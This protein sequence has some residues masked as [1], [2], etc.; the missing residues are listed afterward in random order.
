[1]TKYAADFLSLN[2]RGYHA[3]I[4]LSCLLYLCAFLS[5]A[6]QRYLRWRWPI[7]L[8]R[9][10]VAVALRPTFIPV[11][12]AHSKMVFGCIGNWQDSNAKH[13]FFDVMCHEPV[14]KVYTAIS[15]IC[16]V[17]FAFASIH[18]AMCWVELNPN[19]RVDLGDRISAFA[20]ANGR[21]LALN[22][23]FRV[24]CICFFVTFVQF[25]Y[26][27]WPLALLLL[28]AGAVNLYYQLRHLPH[29]FRSVQVATVWSNAVI[30]WTA[31]CIIINS[32]QFSDHYGSLLTLYSMWPVLLLI[33]ILAVQARVNQVIS[34]S[35]LMLTY[36]SLVS[37]KAR[38]TL[39]EGLHTLG[40]DKPWVV[41]TPEQQNLREKLYRDVEAI[42]Q[43]GTRRFPTDPWL[44][45]HLALFYSCY[46]N[47]KP[48]FYRE[49]FAAGE[50]ASAPDV[51][52]FLFLMRARSDVESALLRS[53]D[54]QVKSYTEFKERTVAAAAAA[55]NAARAMLEFWSDLVRATPNT[56]RLIRLAALARVSTM[57]ALTNYQRLL[58]INPA[59]VSTLR[60]FGGF[61]LDFNGDVSMSSQLLHRADELEEARSDV[62]AG[63]SCE[64]RL[65]ALQ[66]TNLDIYDERNAVLS[67]S[68][69]RE[70]FASIVS[71]NAA[72]RRITGY[73][74]PNELLNRNVSIIIPEPISSVH[75]QILT[76]FLRRNT[77]EILNTTRVAL[78]V[79]KRGYLVTA[80]INMRWVDATMSRV[81]GVIKPLIT[82]DEQLIFD[83]ESDHVTYCT[84]NLY[85]MLGFS[86]ELIVGKEV[87]ISGIFPHLSIHRATTGK[88]R[89]RRDFFL[90]C[91]NQPQG[92]I[93]PARNF[94]DGRLSL[95]RIWMYTMQV[96]DV[97]ISI[98]RISRKI[99]REHLLS[100]ANVIGFTEF[101]RNGQG[102]LLQDVDTVFET[103]T[104][105]RWRRPEDNV[106]LKLT[107]NGWVI[108]R[109]LAEDGKEVDP[110][111]F[112]ATEGSTV[113][114]RFVEDY[115]N[116]SQP[117]TATHF[118]VIPPP[119]ST[120]HPDEPIAD[121]EDHSFIMSPSNN[122]QSRFIAIHK[123]KTSQSSRKILGPLGST[124]SVRSVPAPGRTISAAGT[125]TFT[126][127]THSKP[128]NLDTVA[129]EGAYSSD[130]ETDLGQDPSLNGVARALGSPATT[131]ALTTNIHMSKAQQRIAASALSLLDA[132]AM[133]QPGKKTNSTDRA[134]QRSEM[135]N[136]ESHLLLSS[137]SD[138]DNQS[139]KTKSDSLLSGSSG[140][141]S[142]ITDA[143]TKMLGNR[144][145]LHFI[146]E[147]NKHNKTI[148]GRMHGLVMIGVTS[149]LAVIIAMFVLTMNSIHDNE[150][151]TE[152]LV[153]ACHRR[154]LSMPILTFTNALE[155][156]RLEFYDADYQIDV[157]TTMR[158]AIVQ[159]RELDAS[160]YD[161]R[162]A[163]QEG[164]EFFLKPSI[165]FHVLTNGQPDTRLYNLKEYSQAYINAAAAMLTLPI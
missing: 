135:T 93:L 102:I 35:T 118:K 5:V 119:P 124:I 77:S 147:Q 127:P 86:R 112:N 50:N 52:F 153:S 82:E 104:S 138:P 146:R 15:V 143:D 161:E 79:H 60:S 133:L 137:R 8:Y 44:H 11:L 64:L 142:S 144:H 160:L 91:A 84:Q 128:K 101:E 132:K 131:S 113:S 148:V 111:D 59:S 105:W 16:G 145:I 14:T 55:R 13:A 41:V 9:F 130:E 115:S 88:M 116:Q 89:R 149:I 29:Y 114:A 7:S 12:L 23:F 123:D 78:A 106:S 73:T 92:L 26:A 45:I 109:T 21:G 3:A 2:I 121:E 154:L 51:A 30:V 96:Q 136:P 58:E 24:L 141:S 40:L 6:A 70:N 81:V 152:Y 94:G 99:E 74:L 47:N 56:D 134:D 76:T 108:L 83:K 156:V 165:V 25:N 43:L 162:L 61:V 4:S 100:N 68:L 163:T 151:V 71:T 87:H 75:D 38:L 139:V 66:R 31:L 20:G 36:P 80:D 39:Y 72:F 125:P 95:V 22:L 107:T 19:Q 97:Y 157:I 65:F 34:Y 69:E 129:S 155:L 126:Q 120:T 150:T 140:G 53:M 27:R 33:S 46:I 103:T 67:I 62:T 164:R 17:T 158:N 90:E 1:M 10:L 117:P 37:L 28:T 18:M 49:M 32:I 98:C 48:M 159:F 54:T 110:N 85:S 42:Y 63:T 122:Y 57:S